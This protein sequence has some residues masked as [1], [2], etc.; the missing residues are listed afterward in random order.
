M[1]C[2]NQACGHKHMTETVMHD[3]QGFRAAYNSA[4]KF[5]RKHKCRDN[6]LHDL[7]V[8]AY[9]ECNQCFDKFTLLTALGDLAEINDKYSLDSELTAL[10]ASMF[11]RLWELYSCGSELFEEKKMRDL[12]KACSA[13]LDARFPY[14][15]FYRQNSDDIKID[16]QD[17]LGSL[18]LYFM[19]YT[20]TKHGMITG[21]FYEFI[22][23]NL[24]SLTN[25]VL[26]SC[27]L[28]IRNCNRLKNLT[29]DEKCLDSTLIDLERVLTR[30]LADQRSVFM[31]DCIEYMF[32][33][34][35]LNEEHPS[36]YI[37][38]LEFSPDVCPDDEVMPKLYRQISRRIGLHR[39]PDGT[40]TD[41][42]GRYAISSRK[43]Q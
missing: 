22:V 23:S 34:N 2:P 12:F 16:D 40:F 27:V 11:C 36:A 3:I 25:E 29:N 7:L 32:F 20:C 4:L 41:A 42:R 1:S 39:E 17:D 10:S 26:R 43:V 19:E 18:V 35:Q 37:C 24:E 15:R 6:D 9:V 31:S 33:L 21:V 28:Y 38:T 14:T 13:S 8:N 30:Y 5:Y